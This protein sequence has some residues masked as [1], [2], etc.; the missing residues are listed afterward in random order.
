[1]CLGEPYKLDRNH[2]LSKKIV[3]DSRLHKRQAAIFTG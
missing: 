2:R 3:A 1:M